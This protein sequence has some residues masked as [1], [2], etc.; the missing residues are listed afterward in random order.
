VID[1]DDKAM[2]PSLLPGAHGYRGRTCTT[3]RVFGVPSLTKKAFMAIEKYIGD[4]WW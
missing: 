3:K 4:W 1:I 2:H